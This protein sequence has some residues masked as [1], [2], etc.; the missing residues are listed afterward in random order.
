[1]NISVSPVKKWLIAHAGIEPGL[2]E[3][4]WLDRLL[5][6]RLHTLNVL[7][8]HAYC[9]ILDAQPQERQWIVEQISVNETWFFRYPESFR[10]LLNHL[11]TLRIQPS[12]SPHLSMLSVA[13]A[14]GE[15]P[16]SMAM[17][18]ME[19]GWQAGQVI[20][21]ALD[22]NERSLEIGRRA[23][24]PFR[25]VHDDAPAW[26]SHWLL[27]RQDQYHVDPQIASMVNF[28]PGN[29]LGFLP[30]GLLPNYDVVFCRNLMIYLNQ[31]ARETLIE[32]LVHWLVPGGMLFVGHAERLEILNPHFCCVNQPHTFAMQ[33]LD[34][35]A[36]SPKTP[37]PTALSTSAGPST[38]PVPAANA[39]S[40]QSDDRADRLSSASPS[41]DSTAADWTTT[42]ATESGKSVG[43]SQRSATLA[44]ARNLADGGHLQEALRLVEESLTSE[45]PQADSLKLLGSIQLG[46]GNMSEARRALIK[47]LYLD[48]YQEECLLQLAALYGQLGNEELATRYRVRAA[49]LYQHGN[50]NAAS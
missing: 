17:A 2:L 47:S 31:Q 13:C 35:K 3:R 30:P 50:H 48:P 19:S 36:G 7:D 39:C 34:R 49:K 18:A 37:A 16:Y 27:R 4:E 21:H 15:E 24:Y 41:C 44:E 46:L 11:R 25:T 43:V 14:T 26:A 40:S 23:V 32:R 20:L 33:A 12:S 29:A 10:L 5:A 1:M 38:Q 9:L 22:R 42:P 28:L 45:R 8:E 6:E